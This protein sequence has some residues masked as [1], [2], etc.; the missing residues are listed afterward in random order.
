LI[1]DL[2][3]FIIKEGKKRHCLQS[4]AAKIT[5]SGAAEV[6]ALSASTMQEVTAG[7]SLAYYIVISLTAVAAAHRSAREHISCRMSAKLFLSF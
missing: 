7:C 5:L 2:L 3:L 1:F 4:N 6:I